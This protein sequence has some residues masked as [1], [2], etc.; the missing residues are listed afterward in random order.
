[1]KYGC[2]LN[3]TTNE[4]KIIEDSGKT[5][6]EAINAIIKNVGTFR[7]CF[8]KQIATDKILPIVPKKQ[9]I[10]ETTPVMSL[11]LVE[12]ILLLLFSF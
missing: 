4:N 12:N 8:F 11:N 10:T 3:F 5:F 2:T 9:R 6:I 7:S 1:M